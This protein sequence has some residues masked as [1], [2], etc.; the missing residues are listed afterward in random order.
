MVY[1]GRMKHFINEKD[2]LVREAITGVLYTRPGLSRLDGY[3]AI[4]VVVRS[5]W[6]RRTTTQVALISGGGAGHEPSHVGFVGRGML[7]AAVSGE[8]F[9]SPS[10]DAVLA[11][12]LSVTGDAG[13]LLIVKSYTGDRLNFGLAREKA[14][15]LGKKVEMVVVADDI[16]LPDAPHP[17]GVAGTLF[18]HKV[19]GHVA[20]QGK[21]LAEVTAAAERVA[22]GAG[23]LGI[24]LSSCTIPGQPAEQR[25][26]ANEAELGLGIHGEPGVA[27]IALAPVKELV[28]E[29][30]KRLGAVFMDAGER[31]ALLVNGLGGVP[32]IEMSVV[33][34]CFLE[35]PLGQ[36]VD[37]V[38]GPAPLMTSLDMKGFSLSLL[39][40]TTESREALIADVGPRSWPGAFAV[41][42]VPPLLPL[43]KELAGRTFVASTHEPTRKTLEVI[44]QTLVSN[45]KELDALDAKVGDGDTG[46]TL[47]SAAREISA[48]LSSLPLADAAQLLFA[49][50]DR[51]GV[52]MG[53]SSG[54]LLSIFTAAAGTAL[55]NGVALPG[56]L[57][58]GAS[59]VREVGG[60][61]L[62]DRTMLDAMCPALDALSAGSLPD[63]AKRAREGADATATMLSARA[64]RSSYLNADSL[65]GV[66]D[67]G[68]EAVARVFEALAR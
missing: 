15:T 37:L 39:R 38:V 10:V 35:T 8:V 18:V 33:T 51:L 32:L 2:D 16:A 6:D 45:Q 26:T 63:A 3:P 17:R 27:R 42:R 67:P 20:E 13:C 50:S 68:A 11:A 30:A 44:C 41:Q 43:A 34:K 66:P 19:A 56:A 21:S 36:R 49:L 62:G 55:A 9:A 23:S 54:V 65:R 40:L 64:G 28:S 60:A 31:Y 47:A 14:R 46:S 53:G 59:R 29:M 48:D 22:N 24:A 1:E 57:Q 5:D 58:A 25:M 52:V 12:I 61:K 7:T 4:K